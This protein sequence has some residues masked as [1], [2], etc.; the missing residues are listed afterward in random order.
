VRGVVPDRVR[1]LVDRGRPRDDDD[2]ALLADD[3][4]RYMRLD[5]EVLS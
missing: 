4:L 1:A 2:E 3:A 5:R